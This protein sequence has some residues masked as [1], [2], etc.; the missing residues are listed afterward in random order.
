MLDL[1]F[2]AL[3]R[4]HALL[5]VKP[6]YL[7]SMQQFLRIVACLVICV[8]LTHSYAVERNKNVDEAAIF[9]LYQL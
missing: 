3:L 6:R 1:I 2:M 5:V 8:L 9:F 7:E 4:P